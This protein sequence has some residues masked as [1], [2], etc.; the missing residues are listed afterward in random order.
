M[1]AKTAPASVS[2]EG[3]PHLNSYSAE[4]NNPTSI[5]K[6]NKNK[7]KTHKK[8][9]QQQQQQNS[10]VSYRLINV[11]LPLCAGHRGMILANCDHDSLRT[12]LRVISLSGYPTRGKYLARSKDTKG[13]KE[14]HFNALLM[15]KMYLSYL[16]CINKFGLPP[17]ASCPV[18]RSVNDE[19]CLI[20][21]RFQ[22]DVHLFLKCRITFTQ[23][24]FLE[25]S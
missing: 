12:D 7:K 1:D 5:L 18:N 13:K 3:Q 2:P 6:K 8:Q 23:I 15:K 10:I 14:E 21:Y 16:P 17:S 24:Q 19:E 11:C 4:M 22:R 25:K 9:Q 20:W